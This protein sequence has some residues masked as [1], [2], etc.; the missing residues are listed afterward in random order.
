M[1]KCTEYGWRGH[2]FKKLG[3]EKDN[4]LKDSPDA[5]KCACGMYEAE[6]QASLLKENILNSY[7]ERDSLLF[8]S[9]LWRISFMIITGVVFFIIIGPMFTSD[10]EENC[11]LE[12]TNMTANCLFSSIPKW[13][14]FIMGLTIG[15]YMINKLFRGLDYD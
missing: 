11:N 2:W 15:L 1:S 14:F 13:P 3:P 4:I 9:T 8:S 5:K 10:G 12:N 7:N 6:E